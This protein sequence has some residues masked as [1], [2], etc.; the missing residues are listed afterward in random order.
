[1]TVIGLPGVRERIRQAFDDGILEPFDRS[2]VLEDIEAAGG[3]QQRV[4]LSGIPL[5]MTLRCDR[6]H[7]VQAF[8]GKRHPVI[9]DR[10]AGQQHCGLRRLIQ[11]VGCN[12]LTAI[13]CFVDS[14]VNRQIIVEVNVVI[15]SKLNLRHGT[16]SLSPW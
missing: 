2:L 7:E 10:S 13:W 8:K 3:V 9:D 12:R 1:M 5:R 6:E 14:R 16:I 4:A 15:S 11:T